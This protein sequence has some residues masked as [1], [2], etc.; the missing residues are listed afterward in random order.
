[1]CIRSLFLY[2]CSVCVHKYVGAAVLQIDKGF[3]LFP[4]FVGS[5]KNVH[6]TP[7]DPLKKLQVLALRHLSMNKQAEVVMVCLLHAGVYFA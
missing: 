7:I 4:S 3:V 5:A 2:M 1:M 6:V